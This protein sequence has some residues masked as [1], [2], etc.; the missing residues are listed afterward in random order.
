MKIE[1]IERVNELVSK[2]DAAQ[3]RIKSLKTADKSV[4]FDKIS[5]SG[6][7]ERSG[8]KSSHDTFSSVWDGVTIY[9]NEGT[10]ELNALV[11][12]FV[13]DITAYYEKE[14]K[15]LEVELEAI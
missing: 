4:E 9:L 7:K 3:S 10:P 11:V 8:K 13:E 2:I 15:D 6:I 5:I 12:R 14:L 1:N